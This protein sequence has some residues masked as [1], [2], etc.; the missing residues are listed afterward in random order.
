LYFLNSFE[1]SKRSSK[2]RRVEGLYW[3]LPRRKNRYSLAW[4]WMIEQL[5][6]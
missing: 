1:R 6:F 3:R 4:E 2:K 5:G